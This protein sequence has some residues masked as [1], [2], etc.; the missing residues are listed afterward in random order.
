MKILSTFSLFF[1]SFASYSQFYFYSSK[2]KL[3]TIDS[4]EAVIGSNF[5]N[6]PVLGTY[7]VVMSEKDYLPDGKSLR[8]AKSVQVMDSSITNFKRFQGSTQT[9]WLAKIKADGAKWMS[10]LCS[11]FKLP[12]GASLYI[13]SEDGKEL[14]GPIH[15]TD[16]KKLIMNSGMFHSTSVTLL[17]IEE[18]VKDRPTA[19]FK[20][21][22]IW[23]GLRDEEKTNRARMANVPP[24]VV[25]YF[26][27]WQNESNGIAELTGIEAQ[28]T[29]T[30]LNSEN[31]DRTPLIISSRHCITNRNF[32]T[33][34]TQQERDRLN[35]AILDFGRR[36]I[37][38]GVENIQR[39]FR[40][41][42]AKYLDSWF[43]TDHLLF[44]LD[45]LNLPLDANYLGWN[46]SQT[47][48]FSPGT[49]I[50][51]PNDQPQKISFGSVSDI[52]SNEKYEVTW[53][54][55][56]TSGGSSGSALFN[57]S[58]QVVGNLSYGTSVDAY[59][60]LY[61]SWQTPVGGVGF[62]IS[63]FQNLG[64]MGHLIPL[65]IDGPKEVCY[66]QNATISMPNLRAN[67]T[68]S[69][70]IN[71]GGL[72][73]VSTATHSITL[74]PSS[75]ASNGM[76]T[77]TATITQP[78]VGTFTAVHTL[79][80]GAPSSASGI[81]LHN[82]TT[83]HQANNYGTINL[84]SGTYNNL[85]IQS[86][87][88]TL[89]GAQWSFPGGWSYWTSGINAYVNPLG[90]GNSIYVQAT[91][92]CGTAS[93]P[94]TYSTNLNGCGGYYSYVVYPNPAKDVLTIEFEDTIEEKSFP[95][96]FELFNEKSAKN[97]LAVD[98]SSTT[99]QKELKGTKRLLI[100]VS[101]LPR[102]KYILR[103]TQEK[104][105][106]AEKFKSINIVLE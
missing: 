102:G 62:F 38:C 4:L 25:C 42:G 24:D 67:E 46:R 40:T 51:H 22:E 16:S 66:G 28:C 18:G 105:D 94:S 91:N 52:S 9:Y 61:K 86:S 96:K 21:S 15:R 82:S 8:F 26:P 87:L 98:A 44:T 53:S 10:V 34:L 75:S 59:G 56:S 68:I 83:N 31:Q 27:E 47:G 41:V 81:V 57:T 71:G 11:D 72:Q 80:V 29:C 12:R 93:F 69:W 84:C 58:H 77:I 1:I 76:A 103:V 106:D 104:S 7:S 89:T 17:L 14:A 6:L 48:G 73:T 54:I 64:S 45:N 97:V 78:G 92:Q 23:Y 79:H 30:L 74:T 13:F 101:V 65:R 99:K 39:N 50:H 70:N 36:N 63:P 20:I 37:V 49:G 88:T 100:D 90:P 43:W 32:D 35:N 2:N 3:H 60:K 95:E 85:Y 19:Q 55:G 5:S 33:N